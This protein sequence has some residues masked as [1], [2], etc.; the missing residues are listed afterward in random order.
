MV[1]RVRGTAAL[2]SVPAGRGVS[3]SVTPAASAAHR[4]EVAVAG[5]LAAAAVYKQL[6]SGDEIVTWR[7][8]VDRATKDASRKVDLVDCTAFAARV[9]RQALDWTAGDVIEVSGALRRR[10]WRGAGGLQSR[11]EV[12]VAAA[13]RPRPVAAARAKAATAKRAT[14]RATAT[15]TSQAGAGARAAAGAAAGGGVK[16]R[17]KPE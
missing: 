10:F 4:N 14:G 17:R 6:P 16:R 12:E 2:A 9:R 7:L 8:I 1:A 3:G 11:C 15:S 5:R 13:S